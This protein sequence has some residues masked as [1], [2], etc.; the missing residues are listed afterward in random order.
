MLDI[1]MSADGTFMGF[2]AWQDR[3]ARGVF[4]EPDQPGRAQHRGHL[5]IGKV[6]DVLLAHNERLLSS[7]ADFRTRFHV[8][9]VSS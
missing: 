8:N 7:L 1:D 9:R 3:F 2:Q 6:N 5:V 4:E